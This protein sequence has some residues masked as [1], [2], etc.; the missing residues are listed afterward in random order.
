MRKQIL[1]QKLMFILVVI[2]TVM[3]FTLS[4][5]TAKESSKL[6]IKVSK[7]IIS[8]DTVQ[9]SKND[10]AVVKAREL[11]AF[12]NKI[13][14][15]AH[16]VL[17]A[18]FALSLYGALRYSNLGMLN[19]ILLTL[20][21]AGVISGLDEWNQSFRAGRGM[22]FKDSVSDIIGAGLALIVGALGSVVFW[23]QTQ[24]NN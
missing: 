19:S 20:L 18:A 12:N 3:I 7:K 9:G 6:S 11:A 5:Q 13:R 23:G 21:A 1:M 15:L 2:S 4:S 10:N 16:S 22:E 24:K 17:Y 14:Q 8:I